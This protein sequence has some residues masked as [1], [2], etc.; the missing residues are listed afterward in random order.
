MTAAA[1]DNPNAAISRLVLVL[2]VV[3]MTVFPFSLVAARDGP[4]TLV[5]ARNTYRGD[6]FCGDL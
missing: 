1:A 6:T 5:W 3:F 4:R 2:W